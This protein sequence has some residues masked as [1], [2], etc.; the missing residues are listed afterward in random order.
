MMRP[1]APWPGS[2]A[3]WGVTAKE[4]TGEH[5]AHIRSGRRAQRLLN[6]PIAIGSQLMDASKTRIGYIDLTFSAPKSLSVAWAFALTKAERA[7][8]HLAHKD[9]IESVL[10]DG[11]SRRSGAARRQGWARGDEPGDIGW[12]SFDHD[13]AR[14]TV[15]VTRQQDSG[16]L[17]TELHPLT[18][19]AGRAPGDMQI[20]TH[21]AIF[22]VVETA[23]G[24]VGGLDLARLGGRV[25][26]WGAVYQAYL[27][28]NLAGTVSLSSWTKK[29]RW[30]KISAVP[31]TVIEQFSKRTLNGTDA[32]RA[33]AAWQGLDW[34][35]LSPERK[36]GLLKSGV[37]NPREAKVDGVSDLAAWQRTAETMGYKHRSVL[38]PDEVAEVPTRA[39]RLEAAYRA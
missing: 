18:G 3:L 36:I 14:P 31:E 6:C 28:S 1:R 9:A 24:R 21:V 39:E 5:R 4:I 33:F 13:A 37:Q 25:H 16:E 23:S 34:D 38:R 17:A 15:E 35:S 26:E 27:A 22:N 8:L 30:P 20:H 7:M 2:Q 10:Q 12:V 19:T 32:A 11:C 29:P